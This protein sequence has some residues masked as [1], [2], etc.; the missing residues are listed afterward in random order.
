MYYLAV[1][2]YFFCMWHTGGQQCIQC[3]P[4]QV[5][6]GT[7]SRIV[8]L[9]SVMSNTVGLRRCVLCT[10]RLRCTPGSGRCASCWTRCVEP[11][12][13]SSGKTAS[14][15]RPGHTPRAVLH[16]VGIGDCSG[17]PT[18]PLA[19]RRLFGGDTPSGFW[20]RRLYRMI[21]LGIARPFAPMV[22]RPLA[23]TPERV[24]VLPGTCRLAPP[25]HVAN[26][27]PGR[28]ATPSPH[29]C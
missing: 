6:H 15:T 20:W 2:G 9:R 25:A 7:L 27:S 21:V 14:C 18:R 28:P 26:A 8:F 12:A 1:F 11:I 10:W 16:G 4:T 29:G 23:H 3:G 13:K 17:V 19:P 5:L 22:S 24:T